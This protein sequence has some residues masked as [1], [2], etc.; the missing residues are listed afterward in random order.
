MEYD[1]GAAPRNTIF[2]E[3]PRLVEQRLTLESLQGF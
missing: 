2:F 3:M 1:A